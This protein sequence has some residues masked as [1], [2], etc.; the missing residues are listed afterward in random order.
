[1]IF[2]P[3]WRPIQDEKPKKEKCVCSR[4][5]HLSFNE[6]FTVK[7]PLA[8]HR[9]QH[10]LLLLDLALGLRHLLLT[11][12]D[13][14]LSHFVVAHLLLHLR[15]A[16]TKR[17]RQKQK[18]APSSS[19]RPPRATCLLDEVAV[20]VDV[21]VALFLQLLDDLALLLGLLAVGVD[22]VLQGLLLLLQ[23][24]DETL[25]FLGYLCRFDHVL[26]RYSKVNI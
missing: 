8:D 4:H 20:L 21:A 5:P 6:V 10:V 24:L 14:P 26:Y 3:G 16:D 11:L 23:D 13:L 15:R 18:R 17:G 19:R 1:M 2:I 9:L 25:L 22:L 12:V 7:V